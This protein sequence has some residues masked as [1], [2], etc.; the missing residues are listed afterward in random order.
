MDHRLEVRVI[1]IIKV[2]GKS[3]YARAEI[4]VEHLLPAK[5]G[6]L[7][8]TKNRSHATQCIDLPGATRAKRGP[9]HIGKAP[10]SL[11]HHSLWQW[12]SGEQNNSL[13]ECIESRHFEIFPDRK[14]AT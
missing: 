6:D 4:P 1:K 3:Q 10:A 7:R 2:R 12:C 11:V 14:V 8:A 9:E 13:S 5:Y